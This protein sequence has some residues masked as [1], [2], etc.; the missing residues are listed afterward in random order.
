MTVRWLWAFLDRP[1]AHFDESARFWT[2]VTGTRLSPARGTNSEFV[3]LL[4]DSGAPSVKMQAVASDPRVHLDLDVDDVA[5]ATER[6]VELGATLVL[7]NP[8]YMV[9]KSP[10]GMIFCHTPA[11]RN[12]EDRQLPSR[13]TG[14]A[15]DQSRLDQVCLDIGN[16]AYDDEVRF[17]TELTGWHW[18]PGSLPEFS[19]LTASPALPLRLLLQRLGENRP[20]SAHIDV[21]CTDREATAT[22][23]EKLGAHLIERERNWI[24][25]TDPAGQPYCLTG[26]VPA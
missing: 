21:A 13:V 24:V 26:R 16:D 11:G 23:H 22:W 12:G 5:A 4:P 7:E 9:L 17:W 15:G 18:E 3:T 14:P 20:T 6:A 2:T 25:M 19:R 1:A 8:D 10:H